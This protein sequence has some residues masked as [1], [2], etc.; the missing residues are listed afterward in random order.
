[1]TASSG[2]TRSD[3]SRARK[4]GSEKRGLERKKKQ[5]PRCRISHRTSRTARRRITA[6]P[7]LDLQLFCETTAAQ[8][9]F[10]YR[11]ELF[12]LDW[13]HM[14][15]CLHDRKYGA[16]TALEYGDFQ[17][18][19]PDTFAV[20]TQWQAS[21]WVGTFTWTRES[22]SL[23]GGTVGSGPWITIH[24]RLSSNS[25]GRAMCWCCSTGRAPALLDSEPHFD[26]A[27]VILPLRRPSERDI[28]SHALGG[29]PLRWILRWTRRVPERHECSCDTHR[30]SI[31][32]RVVL[33]MP[34]RGWI[35]QTVRS[36]ISIVSTLVHTF[37]L[38]SWSHERKSVVQK[39]LSH[40]ET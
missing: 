33:T 28:W 40:H 37:L 30:R 11:A 7:D 19:F 1:M 26:D 6:Q 2:S 34:Q 25:H 17:S 9:E 13:I 5:R 16:P 22:G 4:S 32:R 12:L 14:K 10:H 15:D 3:G 35:P 31:I 23:G 20:S 39:V 27:S 38:C 21:A 8:R 18:E 36:H 24:L 29:S